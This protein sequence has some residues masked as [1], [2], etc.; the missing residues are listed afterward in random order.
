[1]PEIS[2]VSVK[3]TAV[4]FFQPMG[5]ITNSCRSVPI[6]ADPSVAGLRASSTHSHRSLEAMQGEQW[7]DK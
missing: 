1:M 6:S 4:G 5:D 2:R 3:T 7:G